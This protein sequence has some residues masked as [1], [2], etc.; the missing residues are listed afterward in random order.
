MQPYAE[1]VF[2]CQATG[3]PR[4]TLFWS[5]EGNRS[6]LFAGAKDA[7]LEVYETPEGRSV[8]TFHR[9]DRAHQGRVVVCSAV[10]SVGSVTSRVVVTLNAQDERPPP[11]IVSGPVNQTLPVNSETRMPCKAVG[12]PQPSVL[13]YHDGI[14]VAPSDRVDVNG[15]G[16]LIL[17]SLD[18]ERDSGVYT[19]VATNQLGSSTASA[20]LVVELPTN[21]NVKFSKAPSAHELPGQPGKPQVVQR[22]DSSVTLTWIESNKIG[23]SPVLGYSVEVFAR[24][25]TEGWTRVADRVPSNQFTQTGLLAGASYYFVVR[26]ENAQG[27][28]PPSAAS[29]GVVVGQMDLETGLDLSEARASLLS[30]EVVE[31][32]SVVAQDSTS[33]KLTWKVS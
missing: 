9:V 33:V 29:D 20:Y 28:S 16:T 12:E 5:V 13:W 30:G 19:C 8:L 7:A 6:L 21:P 15:K 2:E 22:S 31:L 18:K 23:G 14:P 11:V 3:Y 17:A 24:N 26:A 1:V 25:V 4:P 32:T 27:L 10:N